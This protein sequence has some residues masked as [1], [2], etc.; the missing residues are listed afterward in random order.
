MTN[1]EQ[2]D[3]ATI[4]DCVSIDILQF[5]QD[6]FAAVTN[7]SVTIMDMD[8][9]F[10][11]RPSNSIAL[12]HDGIRSRQ[13]GASRCRA[14]DR[15]GKEEALRTQGPVIYQCDNK[16]TD[17][18][19]P[20]MLN[21]KCLAIVYGGQIILAEEQRSEV[22]E[23][24]ESL[25]LSDELWERSVQ[26][27]RHLSRHEVEIASKTM[28][29]LFNVAVEMG[30]N[31]QLRLTHESLLNLLNNVCRQLIQA[32]ESCVLK[33]NEPTHELEVIAG[34]DRYA[35]GGR[36]WKSALSGIFQKV[37][38]SG[39]PVFMEDI[40]E[41]KEKLGWVGGDNVKSEIALPLSMGGKARGM[42]NL[43]FF[44][45]RKFDDDI[46]SF[47]DL[48]G[49]QMGLLIEGTGIIYAF[50]EK[51][52]YLNVLYKI[53]TL[54]S[55]D[56]LTPHMLD[57]AA[58][59]TCEI[60]PDSECEIWLLDRQF[61]RL[62]LMAS[63]PRTQIQ[64]GAPREA[65]L[66]DTL[67]K[68]FLESG[69]PYLLPNVPAIKEIKDYDL[70]KRG[71]P[72]SLA[73]IPLRSENNIQGFL[74]IS[75]KHRHYFITEEVQFLS[76]LGEYIL[77][78]VEKQH[79]YRTKEAL[80]QLA[81]FRGRAANPEQFLQD[82]VHIFLL[83]VLECSAVSIFFLNEAKDRLTLRMTTGI[84]GLTKTEDAWYKK[85]EGMTGW[86][87]EH[88]Q[89]LRIPDDIEANPS[90]LDRVSPRLQPAYKLLE[91]LADGIR[92]QLLAVPIRAGS[93]GELI[94]VLRICG[95]KNN[96][97]FSVAD[98]DLVN[99][100]AGQLG[101]EIHKLLIIERQQS[102][103]DTLS[104]VIET[105]QLGTD[106]K[107][108][109]RE[110]NEKEILYLALSGTT[111]GR[112]LGFNRA[113]A[114]LF[115]EKHEYLEPW[116]A[117]GAADREEAQ[118]IWLGCCNITIKDIIQ[119]FKTHGVKEGGAL[120]ER[121]MKLRLA[122]TNESDDVLSTCC[123]NSKMRLFSDPD[124]LDSLDM[125]SGNAAMFDLFGRHPFV[126]A[127]LQAGQECVG[128]IY[129]DNAFDGRPIQD[130]DVDFL[131]AFGRHAGL[132][133]W[134][135]AATRRQQLEA[136]E[137]YS[138]AALNG[139]ITSEMVRDP[140]SADVTLRK[141]LEHMKE[142]LGFQKFMVFY[143]DQERRVVLI[144][145]S[146]GFDEEITKLISFE[147][148]AIEKSIV[149]RVVQTGEYYFTSKSETDDK[150]N[151][152]WRRDL[153]FQGPFLAV[154]LKVREVICGV[155]VINDSNVKESDE[156]RLKSFA[157]TLAMA[158]TL[159]DQA[160]EL[161][162]Q[163][164]T[165]FLM[166]KV[167]S[168]F[169]NAYENEQEFLKEIAE[170]IAEMFDAQLCA[171]YR[172]TKKIEGEF[173][174]V[175]SFGYP[176]SIHEDVRIAQTGERAGLTNHTLAGKT[177][178]VPD[179][180]KDIRWLGKQAEQLKDILGPI[181]AFLGV[182]IKAPSSEKVIGAITLTRKRNLEFDGLM[183]HPE[184]VQLVEAMAT[185]VT[186]LLDVLDSHRQLK[187]RHAELDAIF[188]AVA[189]KLPE[190]VSV[191]DSNFTITYAN[192]AKKEKFSEECKKYGGT[193]EGLKCYEVY[194][195]R[196]SVCPSCPIKLAMEKARLRQSVNVQDNSHFGRPEG[197]LAYPALCLA[198]A[199]I[200]DE[201]GDVI[202][203]EVVSD[204]G[205]LDE[206]IYDTIQHGAHVIGRSLP[207]I[208][209]RLDTIDLNINQGQIPNDLVLR[210]HL[211]RLRELVNNADTIYRA[212][213]KA[214][215]EMK[216]DLHPRD[217]GQLIKT[218]LEE[219]NIETIVDIQP[220]E[221][222][223]NVKCDDIWMKE[224][225]RELLANATRAV[226]STG[227]TPKIAVRLESW[228]S[229]GE[230]IGLK[231]I[232]ADNGPGI[233]RDHHARVFDRFFASKRDGY[234]QGI[235]L[236]LV[237][238]IIRQHEGSIQVNADQAGI[239]VPFLDRG[240]GGNI[241]A[242]FEIF[243]P[244]EMLE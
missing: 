26:N 74:L 129:A 73:W 80:L 216:L 181:R 244:R 146:L 230:E 18:A 212:Q 99:S 31:G 151:E 67:I 139:K 124:Q 214:F 28:S 45:A 198:S 128:I 210:G 3:A 183:F 21:G 229:A 140:I 171:F 144:R 52:R 70:L 130:E 83:D 78:A 24:I 120:Q 149:A 7:V 38:D 193:L 117:I 178:S 132:A 1:D 108:I 211:N 62:E 177:I 126:V 9:N 187:R 114:W 84:Q 30:Y 59:D 81:G 87:W 164:K 115:D 48:L 63:A 88:E 37:I 138:R 137:A 154:P 156:K 191:V 66:G 75:C 79:L 109:S 104:Q 49:K 96:R 101:L 82:I 159:A 65:G 68:E 223:W 168:S 127:P 175:S 43:N 199:Y 34:C 131:E 189:N 188:K 234:H 236:S 203:V 72:E 160:K 184:E 12:C 89:S 22:T 158:V 231:I 215:G 36:C 217:I 167:Y 118:K 107:G 71:S 119:D 98:E 204:L 161:T 170:S 56:Q 162:T 97:R 135:L 121:F 69:K 46:R 15:R 213:F 224:A 51:A 29:T 33:L 35:K 77:S 106:E 228:V 226:Q 6:S 91:V 221:R 20:I 100:I 19:A 169:S 102:R 64:E 186:L 173:R 232:F 5:L 174:R 197:K 163:K 182:P 58:E 243:F 202:G 60:I 11:T 241:G 123:H 57:S 200:D 14:S 23:A 54:L 235:G 110:N 207:S 27:L 208:R 225:F 206:E 147:K 238:R 25:D 94:G 195:K 112:G 122:V 176:E 172:P 166:Q 113:C 218:V 133:I 13:E 39:Q 32:D 239:D 196:R 92:R 180:R 185:A 41:G 136:D 165:I 152:D 4:L 209:T 219:S 233:H 103:V 61:D 8:G 148:K 150:I 16:L 76:M 42:L 237:Q 205:K 50:V 155:L 134:K 145:G 93:D 95:Q 141:I 55:S 10:I 142:A 242:I 194:E 90:V 47:V 2:K 143:H 153:K 201:T 222:Q 44:H 125:Q 40:E 53:T 116:I 220:N 86:V 85:G 192:P 105:I 111:C 17:F 190:E 227:R 157:N 240:L 179:V